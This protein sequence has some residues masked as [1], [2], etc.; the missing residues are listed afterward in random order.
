[1]NEAGDLGNN[2]LVIA[3]IAFYWA[4]LGGWN[5]S[6]SGRR[7]GKTKAGD[8]P[9]G[10]GK[11]ASALS[12]LSDAMRNMGP[13][14]DAEAFLAGARLTYEAVLKAYADADIDMLK[15][16]VGPEVLETFEQVIAER[17]ERNESLVL[18]FIGMNDATLVGVLGEG[19]GAEIA[20]R[21]TS[22]VVTV[23]RS[24]GGA[25][26][27]GDPTQIVEVVDTWTFARDRS[28]AH[29]PWRLIATGGA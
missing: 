16:F 21:F 3:I 13:D 22:D 26:V 19:D 25:V 20:V 17:R 6:L 5:Q 15:R 7:D 11:P 4:L 29:T 1:M 9:A 14:F 23:V 28:S 10:Y 8:V 2:I 27:S 12:G 18:T 24:A